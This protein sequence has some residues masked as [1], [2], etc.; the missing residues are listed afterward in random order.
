MRVLILALTVM[1]L[2]TPATAGAQ[3]AASAKHAATTGPAPVLDPA[4]AV[5]KQA[6]AARQQERLAE[7]LTLYRKA[8]QLNPKSV[9]AWWAIGTLTYDQ[10]QFAA[11]APA[12]NR[13]VVLRPKEAPGWTM[14]GLCDYGTRSYENAYRCL[15]HADRLGF[16]GTPELAKVGRFHL[17]LLH[18]HYSSFERALVVLTLLARSSPIT[19]EFAAAAGIAGLRKTWL[20]HEVPE[21]ERPLVMTFGEALVAAFAQEPKI[22]VAKFE[23][24]LA[25]YPDNP[26]I[27]YRLGAY[28]MKQGLDDRAV[29]EMK[30]ALELDPGHLPA[31]V[32]LSEAARVKG[33]LES[34]VDYGL[35]ALKLAPDNFAA[36][37]IVGRAYLGQE[38]KAEA[39]VEL[40]L[41]VKLAP[42]S[43]DAHYSL[44]LAYAAANRSKDAA[45]ERA[46]FDR[47][48]N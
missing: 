18:S 33:E 37:L 20:L 48:K 32:S 25:A 3:S 36:H 16:Q 10:D 4:A 42:D 6:D 21:S 46:E 12:F 19:P 9:D 7:A 45:R 27:H 13:L 23:A 39:V 38:R 28:L 35:R 29:A 8:A 14:A 31:L 17:A 47:M 15:L 1:T 44:S 24:A 5:L 40:Q 26:D 34:S 11:C 43:P 22:A 2:L 30:R 41:A